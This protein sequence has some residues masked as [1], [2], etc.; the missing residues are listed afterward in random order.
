MCA[1]RIDFMIC[2]MDFMKV[3]DNIYYK[4]TSLS[5]H[6]IVWAQVDLSGMKRGPGLWILNTGLLKE[7]SFKE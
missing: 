6:K 1:S 5:D 2:K 7:I 3:V 4:E